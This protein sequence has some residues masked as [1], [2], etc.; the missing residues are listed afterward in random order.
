MSCLQCKHDLRVLTVIQN[1]TCDLFICVVLLSNDAL[2][3]K[4]NFLYFNFK[5]LC[6][7]RLNLTIIL[8]F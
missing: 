8:K 5:K 2:K 4:S 1:V 6:K 3:S 7:L